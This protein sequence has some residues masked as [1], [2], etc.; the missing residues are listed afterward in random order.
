M[1]GIKM[2]C[3]E[4]GDWPRRQTDNEGDVQRR[5]LTGPSTPREH[6]RTFSHGYSYDYTH[7]YWQPILGNAVGGGTVHYSAVWQRLHRADFRARTFD[8]VAEDWPISYEDLA[9]YYDLVDN[10]VGISGVAGNPAYP[11]RHVTFLPIPK[12]TRTAE[13][14]TA[15]FNKLGW[16]WWPTERAVITTEYRGRKPCPTSCSACDDGCPHES[17]NSSDVV[18]WR[19]AVQ[20]GVI[21][22][23]GARVREITV[24]AKGLADGAVYYDAGG[25]LV[26][27][28]ARIVV[29]A[30]NGIG[31]PR[32]LLNSKSRHFPDGLANSTGLVGRGLMGHPS[33]NVI[34]LL[35]LEEDRRDDPAGIGIVSDQF[36]QGN[37]GNGF[38]RGMWILAGA[39]GPPIALALGEGHE[40]QAVVVPAALRSDRIARA[41]I[42]WGARHHTAFQEQIGRSINISIFAEEL[43]I[44]DNRVELDPSLADETGIPGIKLFSTR[45]HNAEKI[46]AFGIERAREVMQVLGAASVES[47]LGTSAPGHYLGTARMGK[48]PKRSVVD[49]WGRAHDV[50]NLFVIDGSVFTTGGAVVPTSTIQALAVRTAAYIKRNARNV[51]VS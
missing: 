7:S 1:R 36:A 16:H 5:R 42:S 43:P 47:H 28:K 46:L 11:P 6:V 4:Q 40:P 50:R 18:F 30:C 3:L 45:T 34:G 13:R 25:Q 24:N 21:L 20:N 9:P 29:V 38:A 33:A 27:Q 2:M 26:S 51:I 15:G 14:L 39:L 44:D 32:L 37:L 22:R 41:P 49:E 31:T 17:K 10:T 19:E 48:D 8:S 23:T 12:L 35:P